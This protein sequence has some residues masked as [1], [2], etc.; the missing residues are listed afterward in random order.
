MWSRVAKPNAIG[1]SAVVPRIVVE[2]FVLR[3]YS[4]DHPP[5]HV[6]AFRDGAEIRIYLHGSRPPE[7][8]AGQLKASDR[9]RAIQLVAEHR[10]K[11]LAMWRRFH[12]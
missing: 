5:A 8:V 4:D 7:E 2:G 6:H 10:T 1:Y 9:R 11:L 3:V 12:S